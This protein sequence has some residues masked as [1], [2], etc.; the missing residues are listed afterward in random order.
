MRF[1]MALVVT[2]IINYLGALI[3]PWW[4]IAIGGLVVSLIIHQAPWKSFLAG[5]AGCFLLWFLIAFFIDNANEHVLSTRV[6][7]LFSLQPFLLIL[8]SAFTG[9]FVTGM[10]ALS[11]SLFL[12][13]IQRRRK[14]AR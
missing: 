13:T 7:G 3:F 11:G 6:G 4:I 2:A 1:L 12:Q 10:A 14:A 8:L 9:G 5:F